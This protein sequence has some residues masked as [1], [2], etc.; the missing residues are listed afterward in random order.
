MTTDAELLRQYIDEDYGIEG[1]GRW[2]RS[3][4]HSSLV[5]DMEKEIF[6]FNSLGIIG[7]PFTYLT[8][9]RKYSV[10]RANEELRR[11]HIIG[12]IKKLPPKE[13]VVVLEDLV[14]LFHNVGRYNRS[15]WYDR[16][17]INETIDRFRLGY[18]N[19]YYLVPL[20]LDGK[21]RNFQMRKDNPKKIGAWY[22]GIGAVPFNF[23]ILKLVNSVVITEGTV[24]AILLN[25]YG[26]PSVSPSGPNWLGCWFKYFINVKEIYYVADND[27][28]GLV[29]AKRA[30]DLLGYKRTK[31]ITFDGEREKYDTIDFFREKE[32]ALDKF[33]DLMYNK[34]KYIFEL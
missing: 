34:S 27:S 26:I 13:N 19:N 2:F 30:A 4:D 31:I 24:D 16:L 7:G 18:F 8:K 5:L 25:Q 21:F 28:A 15:Y 20:Y 33:K 1:S 23:D 6:Y 11:T 9:V 29:G 32:N 14:Y 12:V 17:L 3:A 22:R 10:E